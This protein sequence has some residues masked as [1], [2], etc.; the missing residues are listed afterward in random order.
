[1]VKNNTIMNIGNGISIIMKVLLTAFYGK[2]NASNML[3]NMI[4]GNVD[5]LILTNSF[6]KLEQQL[7]N[8]TL[9]GYDLILMFGIN[10]LLKDEIRLDQTAKLDDEV[11]TCLDIR[12]IS[13]LCNKYVK[14]SINNVPTKYLCNSAYYHTLKKNKNTLF[15]H[16]P[17]FNKITNMNLIVDIIKEI[18]CIKI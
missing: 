7:N 10:K 4:D 17:G 3:V 9:E 2:Y 16:I 14:T 13:D 1:M 18:I 15:V 11:N 5:K 8:T 12:L 6:V